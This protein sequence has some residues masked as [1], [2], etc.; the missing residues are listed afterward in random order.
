ML[1]VFLFAKFTTSIIHNILHEMKTSSSQ[2]DF[3]I[4]SMRF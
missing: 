1:K 2:R 3:R 4:E